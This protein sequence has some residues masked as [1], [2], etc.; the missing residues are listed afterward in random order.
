MAESKTVCDVA[1][2]TERS[3]NTIRW[4][5]GEIF[6]KQG[7]TRLGQLVKLVRSLVKHSRSES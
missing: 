7:G 1:V 2:A 3:V 6:E 5:I 4:H